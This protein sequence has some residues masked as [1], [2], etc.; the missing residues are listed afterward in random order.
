M[1]RIKKYQVIS[2]RD[3][4]EN[5]LPDRDTCFSFLPFEILVS[6]LSFFFWF[7]CVVVVISEL[8]LLGTI[9]RITKS[10]HTG[11]KKEKKGTLLS[12]SQSKR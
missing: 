6:F 4:P 9:Q 11:I 2:I 1:G 5:P 7:C 3:E 8:V 10:L 12:L